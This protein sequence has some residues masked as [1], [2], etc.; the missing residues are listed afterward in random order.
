MRYVVGFF[1]TIGV[2]FVLLLAVMFWG[3]SNL[4]NVTQHPAKPIPSI[5]VLQLDLKGE[6]AEPSPAPELPLPFGA[7]AAKLRDLVVAIDRAR[8]DDRI[9]GIVLHVGSAQL[10]MAQAQ[11]LRDALQ[12]FRDRGKF[13]IAHADSWAVGGDSAYLLATGCD[14]VWMQ[15]MGELRATGWNREFEFYKGL[16]EKVGVNFEVSK[17]KE[18]KSA[19]DQFTET[20]LPPAVRENYET[21]GK[22]LTQQLV[23]GI[24][25]GRKIE[26][27][28]VRQAMA[29][30]PL[31]GDEAK[32]G[33]FIDQL[34]HADE[35][36]SAALKRAGAGAQFVKYDQF[37]RQ[38]E[39]PSRPEATKIAVIYAIGVIA[40]FGAPDF[41]GDSIVTPDTMRKAFETAID[42]K[43]IKA[44]VLRVDSPGGEVVA[45]ESIRRLVLRAKESGKK[46]VVSMGS[47][48]ASGGYWISMDADK[49]VAEPATITGSIGVLAER[50]DAQALLDKLGVTVDQVKTTDAPIMS[51]ARPASAQE[52]ERRNASL[53]R[54]YASFV[55]GVA[56]GRKLSP[57]KVEAIAR[58]RVW[59]G[60][61]AKDVGLVDEL[62]GLDV[63]LRVTRQELGLPTDSPLVATVLPE[64][65]S[66]LEELL[67]YMRGENE[68]VARL[69]SWAS[70]AQPLLRAA[71]PLFESPDARTLRLPA[72]LLD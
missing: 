20:K 52:R 40:P 58:G 5:A 59:T 42:D 26:P 37:R 62:G 70:V 49:I 22:D 34:G 17:R 55:D 51:L 68:A 11:E 69:A 8:T 47:V 71:S 50:P 48:A 25:T 61:Q 35:A 18:Y 2:L 21:L 19:G 66:P 32:D 39:P 27:D 46:I 67:R 38:P 12:R 63:A 9:K 23:D 6:I 44:I 31:F 29:R 3:V 15:P 41:S 16:L 28:S 30:M 33:H 56:K 53:D 65:R 54:I 57:D 43:A 4:K 36:D 13:A 72:E 1:A 64:R 10:R 45:G 24:A 60:K 14:E 7:R